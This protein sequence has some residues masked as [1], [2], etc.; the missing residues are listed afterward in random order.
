M[1]EAARKKAA[2]AAAAEGE[3]GGEA[4][5]TTWTQV[6]LLVGLPALIGLVVAGGWRV[7][8]GGFEGGRGDYVPI[9]AASHDAQTPTR[10]AKMS[11]SPGTPL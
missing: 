5:G 10:P 6:L 1:A 3:S 8:N 7:Y 11:S 2:A 4:G 9:R